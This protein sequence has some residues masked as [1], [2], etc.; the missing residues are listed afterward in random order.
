VAA[1]SGCSLATIKRK[2]ARAKKRFVAL[3]AHDPM[4]GDRL[5]PVEAAEAR[6]DS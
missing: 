4:L 6:R 3:A 1:M 2:L 5:G